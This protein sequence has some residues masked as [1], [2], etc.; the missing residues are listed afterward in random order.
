MIAEHF[1]WSCL[2]LAPTCRRQTALRDRV[3]RTFLWPGRPPGISGTPA[4]FARLGRDRNSIPCRRHGGASTGCAL[5]PLRNIDRS[6]TLSHLDLSRL[7]ENYFRRVALLGLVGDG[8]EADQMAA[9][10]ECSDR[11]QSAK[12][13]RWPPVADS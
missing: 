7:P 4:A 9:A 10:G 6:R 1:E 13:G 2:L 11:L 5:P 8:Y 12:T 3:K